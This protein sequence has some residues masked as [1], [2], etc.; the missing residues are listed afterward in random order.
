MFTDPIADMLT[1]IRNAGRARNDRTS[2]P[3]S[4]IKLEICKILKET[5]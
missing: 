5:G 4:R 3:L 1:R 2:M